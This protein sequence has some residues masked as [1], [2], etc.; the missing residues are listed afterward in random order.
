M[1]ASPRGRRRT[2]TSSELRSQAFLTWLLVQVVPGDVLIVQPVGR[3]PG[4]VPLAQR[5]PTHGASSLSRHVVPAQRW[6]P[7]SAAESC[8]IRSAFP[9]ARWALSTCHGSVARS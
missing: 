3:H 2:K 6:R 5:Q 9:V 1:A 4:R 7:A 8:P